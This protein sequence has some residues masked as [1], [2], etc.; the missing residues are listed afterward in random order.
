M[1]GNKKPDAPQTG[2]PDQKNSFSNQP[3]KPASA[4]WEGKP[5]MSTDAMRP[6]GATAD[7]ATARLGASLH[8]KGEISGNE[9]LL[10]D[11]SVEGLVQLDERKLTVGATAKVTADIIAREVVVY[12]TV[13]GNLR[14]KDRIEIK[15]DG[16]VNGDLT[17]A[18]IMIEDGAYFKGSIE[19]DKT[20]QKESGGNAFARASAAPAGATKTI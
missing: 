14:A 6:L 1:W 13:K 9:D 11:G 19:I 3:P 15:K 20:D 2:Q 18:R 5:A 8:V 4:A 10:I 17:T 7:R 16:S 12:G